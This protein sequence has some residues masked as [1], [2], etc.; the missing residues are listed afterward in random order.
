MLAD[1]T[2]RIIEDHIRAGRLSPG[3]RGMRRIDQALRQHNEANT[4]DPSDPEFL[5]DPH[6]A[7]GAA[8]LALRLADHLIPPGCTV[9]LTDAVPGYEP[10]NQ[11]YAVS[12]SQVEAAME[13]LRQVTGDDISGAAV[14]AALPWE[15][16]AEDWADADGAA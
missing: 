9:T 2:H 5:I 10:S 16:D 8:R 4:L 11:T 6:H 7:Q 1:F 12:P 3:A 15:H 13:H 14:C